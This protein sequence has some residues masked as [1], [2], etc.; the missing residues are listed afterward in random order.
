M[1]DVDVAVIGAG[2]AGLSVAA[3]AAGLGL[4]VALFERGAMGGDC[5]NTGCVPSKALLA[6]AHAAAEARRAHRFGIHL[7]EPRIDWAGVR[8]HVAGAI[9]AI[10]PMDSEARYRAMGATVVR[11]SARFAGRDVIEAAGRRFHF[12]RAVVAAGSAPVIP[13]IPGLAEVPFLTSDTLFTLQQASGHLLILGGGPIGLEMAQ[14]HVRLGCRVS[15]IEAATIAGRE[16]PECIPPLRAALVADEQRVTLREVTGIVRAAKNADEAAIGGI[17]FA[18]RNGFGDDARFR[19]RAH[20]DHLRAGV[21]LLSV[22]RDSDGVKFALGIVALQNTGRVFPC[23]GGA[24]F[25]LRP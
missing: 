15:V 8:A 21:G 18:R 17:R 23:D 16:D 14:A 11:G 6:A 10:A 22:V 13:P 2:A 20:M 7:P 4:K 25:D 5:L 19:V 9:A 3:I 12:R 24:C 1:P